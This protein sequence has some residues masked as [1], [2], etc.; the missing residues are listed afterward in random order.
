MAKGAKKVVNGESNPEFEERKRLKKLAHSK[1]LLTSAPANDFTPLAPSKTLVKHHGA[2]ILKKSQRK[3]RYL[4]SFCGLLAPITGGKIGE[5]TNL[6]SKNPTLYLDFPQGRM[7]LCGTIVYPNNRYLT[8]QFS[9]GG[10]NVMCEDYF[11]TMMG[12]VP[13]VCE[14]VFS[15]ACWVGNK[16]ENPQEKRLPFP[17]EIYENSGSD[18]DFQGGA[19]STFVENK[20]Y[21][22]VKKKS[23]EDE[24]AE[25]EMEAQSP[26]REED[27]KKPL[28]ATPVRHSERTAGKKF[29]FAIDASSPEDFPQD[30]SLDVEMKD[31]F[32]EVTPTQDGAIEPQLPKS[33]VSGSINRKSSQNGN[34]RLVQATIS[35]LLKKVNTKAKQSSSVQKTVPS[36]DKAGSQSDKK[37]KIEKSSNDDILSE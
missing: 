34:G 22:K 32:C 15:D 5:L 13:N 25:A 12:S 2:D 6:G 20:S 11:D 10:K 8:L 1:N 21:S 9:K 28:D 31:S 19:G 37:K 16:D 23:A 30:D 35:T 26:A 29:K 27:M 7:K 33:A 17:V 24:C 14:I 36:A 18:Y 4:F 3:N